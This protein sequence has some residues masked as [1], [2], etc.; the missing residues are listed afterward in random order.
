MEAFLFYLLST[1]IIDVC[2]ARTGSHSGSSGS[3]KSATIVAIEALIIGGVC[4]F[5]L[6]VVCCGRKYC[7]KRSVRVPRLYTQTA[8]A[9][10][11]NSYS[12]PPP[13]TYS[14]PSSSS[15]EPTK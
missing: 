10:Q 7:Q 11:D 12:P 3:S 6:I 4:I 1:V 9:Q 13:Y 15:I 2:S 5:V 14:T 8:L